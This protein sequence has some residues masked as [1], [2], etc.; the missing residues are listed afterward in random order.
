MNIIF[1]DWKFSSHIL[2]K[3]LAFK[4]KPSFKVLFNYSLIWWSYARSP[5][6]FSIFTWKPIVWTSLWNMNG[7]QIHQILTTWLLMCLVQCRRHFTNLRCDHTSGPDGSP[8]ERSLK[9][10]TVRAACMTAPLKL[11]TILEL[12]GALQ[13]IRDDLPETFA[14]SSECMCCM[15]VLCLA[16]N[17]WRFW[18]WTTP[19]WRQLQLI[20]KQSNRQGGAKVVYM[21]L[22]GRSFDLVNPGVATPLI[23]KRQ[24]MLSDIARK[25]LCM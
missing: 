9:T 14:I 13:H 6:E 5:R 15:H 21:Y 25:K 1:K 12:K 17:F 4:F 8:S 22:P 20:P 3:F 18:A 23:R 24:Q 11:K 2:D 16:S 10:P 19:F 7:H